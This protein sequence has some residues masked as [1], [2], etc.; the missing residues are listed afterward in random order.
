M[1]CALVFCILMLCQSA[2][3]KL[4]ET[5]AQV[6]ARYGK[7]FATTNEWTAETRN[8]LYQEYKI[9]VLF[10]KG[11]SIQEQVNG[12]DKKPDITSEEALVLARLLTPWKAKWVC[13]VPGTLWQAGQF[14]LSRFDSKYLSFERTGGGTGEILIPGGITVEGQ[15]YR[16]FETAKERAEKEASMK[17]IEEKFGDKK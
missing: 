9:I 1:K 3:A 5:F 12:S 8:Y 15:A 13:A 14:K 7:S 10:S 16:D 6:E 2:F 4:G 17:S 11:V